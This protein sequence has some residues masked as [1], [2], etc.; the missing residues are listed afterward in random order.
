MASSALRHHSIT[1]NGIR[2]HLAEQGEGPLVLLCHGWPELRYS[3]RHQLPA[4]AAA[5]YRAVAPD[6]R[7]YGRTQAPNDVAAYS[8]VHLVGDVVALVQVLGEKS[9]V[10][11]GHDWGA[12]VA[13]SAAMMRSDVFRA[14]ATMSVPFRQRGPAPP[15]ALLRAMG[16][17]NFYWIYFQDPGVAEAEFE[18]DVASTFRRFLSWSSSGQPRKASDSAGVLKPGGGFLDN[19]PVPK[20]LPAWLAEDDIAVM[21]GEFERTGFRGGLNWY[22]NLDRNW[23]LTAPW[24]GARIEQ[25]TLFIAGAADSV[26]AGPMG[27]NALEQMPVTVPGL[28]R[29]LIIEGAGHWIQ[30]EKAAEVNAALLAFLREHAA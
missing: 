25:P 17:A 18:R 19:A 26:I 8:I 20:S 10:I 2:F 5:G 4:V 22:R 27:R 13:W 16:L 14:V 7:G 23:E 24:A 28:K 30:Q 15:L 29:Q 9:A 12:T 1:A 21:A 3:W 6:M 11:V